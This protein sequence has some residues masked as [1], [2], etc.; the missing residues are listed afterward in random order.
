MTGQKIRIFSRTYWI[1][2]FKNLNKRNSNKDQNTETE[3]FS[4]LK[5][6]QV[7]LWMFVGGL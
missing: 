5:I 1:L 7:H 3:L 4:N 2:I 6:V